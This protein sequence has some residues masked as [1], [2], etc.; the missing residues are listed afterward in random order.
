MTEESAATHKNTEHFGPLIDF[1]SII[2][3]RN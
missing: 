1:V 2:F 3:D